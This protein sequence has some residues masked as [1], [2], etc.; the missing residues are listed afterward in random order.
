MRR[1]L[2]LVLLSIVLLGSSY[3]VTK[4]NN[5][6]TKEFN[7]PIEIESED[8]EDHEGREQYFNLI[9]GGDEET[10]YDWKSNYEKIRRAKAEARNARKS[11]MV[12]S[13]Q[14][15]PQTESFANGVI[16]GTW[17]E[18]G[19]KNQ[20]GRILTVELLEDS[21]IIYIGT[22]GGSVVRGTL[23][24]G[25]DYQILN[26]NM[27]FS[28]IKLYSFVIN[29]KK[30]IVVIDK[31]GVYYSDNDGVT[32]TKSYDGV[33]RNATMSRSDNTI[34]FV[35]YRGN[36]YQSTDFGESFHKI[37]SVPDNSS[38]KYAIWTP[39][40]VKGPLYVV[41]DGDV[42]KFEDSAQS[43][44]GSIPSKALPVKM[45]GDDS[46]D[47]SILYIKASG[48]LYKSID[49]GTTWS[50]DTIWDY[51]ADPVKPIKM[52][53]HNSFCATTEDIL[54]TGSLEC[55]VSNDGGGSWRKINSWTKYYGDPYSG[56]PAT[57]LHAD[58]DGA[59]SFIDK[60]GNPI[61][62]ISTDGGAFITYDN[63]NFKNITLTNIRNNMYYGIQSRWEDP[64]IILVGAQD[65]GAQI[66]LPENG[67]DI[68]D[69]MQYM[70]GDQGSY[71]SSDSGKS[72]WL[73]YIRGSLYYHPDTKKKKLY[74][75]HQPN[76]NDDYIWMA[77]TVADPSNPKICYTGGTKVYKTVYGGLSQDSEPIFTPSEQ[78]SKDFG[79]KIT[80][81]AISSIDNNY[82]YVVTKDKVLYTST[83]Y[84]KTWE[85]KG[86]SLPAYHWLVGQCVLP[87]NQDLNTVYVSGNGNGNAA[88]LVS[89]DGGSTFSAF[90]N[91]VPTTQIHKMVQTADGRFIYAAG[92]DAA[93]V[94]VK[95]DNTWYNMTGNN[96]P[97]VKYFD[98]EYIPT[99]KTVRFATHGRGIWDFILEDDS[100]AVAIGTKSTN[101]TLHSIMINGINRG[102]LS[103]SLPKDGVY[104]VTLHSLNGRLLFN[105]DFSLKAGQQ[106][107]KLGSLPKSI[108]ILSVS[109]NGY[110]LNKKISIK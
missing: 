76:K 108:S 19:A 8:G 11:R 25:N 14:S 2:L 81:M 20:A 100:N 33:P 13:S 68:M 97:D 69:F 17:K 32:W 40:Y 67:T 21:N 98:V 55:Y 62:I 59:E 71:T 107:I 79:A 105:K 104:N 34:T 4:S 78:S 38:K 36:V 92:Y 30:R 103:L 35:A 29:D 90:G 109:G 99:I 1:K 12:R 26:N 53:G 5:I 102:N 83:D 101:K 23:P 49:G 95:D 88:V 31:N 56:D 84:G 22:D 57:K 10:P 93:Y 48:S 106:S 15:I 82:W 75:A 74:S 60:N 85:S 7:K 45:D 9:F 110:Y 65:Q 63:S 96:G 39:R 46:K 72:T 51:D 61:T 42:Y 47:S 28:V 80:A 6:N 41:S 24:E 58:I 70:S 94:Y 43:K 27:Q 73:T 66:S 77:P 64:D 52:F 18:R 91:D 87:D 16:K 86:T 44:I 37:G 89:T 3:W 50:G 54:Y